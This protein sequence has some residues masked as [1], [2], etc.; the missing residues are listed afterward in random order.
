LLNHPLT[1]RGTQRGSAIRS[2]VRAISRSVVL[3][4][5][6][7]LTFAGLAS[8]A[9]LTMMSG[10]HGQNRS[11]AQSND[12]VVRSFTAPVAHEA[13]AN[14][15]VPPFGTR[16]VTG[17]VPGQLGERQLV[18]EDI[19]PFLP[20][21]D[22][23][24]G[25]FG[26]PNHGGGGF[27]PGVRHGRTASFSTRGPII[28]TSHTRVATVVYQPGQI[29]RFKLYRVNVNTA[30]LV[31]VAEGCVPADVIP[32]FQDLKQVRTVPTVPCQSTVG[33]RDRLSSSVPVELSPTSGVAGTISGF[34]TGARWLSV[35]QT[36]GVCAPDAQ[37]EAAMTPD[38][39]FWQVIGNFS[40]T[41][42]SAT[43]KAPGFFCIY[44][45]TGG[46]YKVL[47][48]GRDVAVPDGRLTV[49]GSEAFSA[50]DAITI[51]APPSATAG[52]QAA[53]TI[54]GTSSLAEHL[55]VFAAYAPCASTA[56][57]E[58]PLAV[59]YF[60]QAVRGAFSIPLNTVP[61]NQTATVCAYLQVGTPT[62]SG[63]PTG[64]T[65][66]SA[67]QVITVVAPTAQSARSGRAKTD[68][69]PGAHQLSLPGPS[70]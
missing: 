40:V 30:N 10:T 54:A 60:N 22:E 28:L 56:E 34:T 31:L 42:T 18:R 48:G 58:Y 5:A 68:S 19:F 3:A 61:L 7:L 55:Y 4:T 25:C 38:H 46:T 67:S 2:T 43:A 64:P 57:S 23:I 59:G 1:S 9:R 47:T 35:F 69:R 51:G 36:D 24:G 17:P 32:A 53:T 33:Q 52:Q 15:V 41:F 50:G 44:L 39:V 66:V 37:A 26:C 45:Q 13:N 29:G 21:E 12:A 62:S 14:A 65:L 49:S 8:G 70:S 63:V 6:L 16:F 27:K 20:T 11:G